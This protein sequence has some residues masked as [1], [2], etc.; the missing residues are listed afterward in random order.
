MKTKLI[1]TAIIL[2]FVFSA[3]AQF[4]LDAQYRIRGQM[5]HG[6]KKPIPE[7]VDP[8]I[9][10]G[11]RTR[12]NL[13]YQ[14]ENIKTRLSVQDVRV[15]GDENVVNPTG[16]EGKNIGIT[17]IYEAWVQIGLSEKSFIKLGRQEMKYD[18]QRHISWRNWWDTGQTYDAVL[19]SYKNKSTGWQIDLSGSYNSKKLDL[20][21]NDYSD[22]TAYFGTVNPILTHNF[23]YILKKA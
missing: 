15:W 7:N 23:I 21:G 14:Y 10:I 5:L 17:D 16:V 19:F 4:K 6:Y 18:D 11:Q 9:H 22:G 1:I 3:Q 8:A 13:Q 20:T 12:L 2:S